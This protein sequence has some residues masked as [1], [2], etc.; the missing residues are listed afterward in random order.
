MNN[1][2]DEN[3]TQKSGSITVYQRLVPDKRPATV[4]VLQ[5]VYETYRNPDGK[6]FRNTRN[7]VLLRIPSG[8]EALNEG[9][10]IALMECGLDNKQIAHVKRRLLELAGPARALELEMD[11]RDA[12]GKLK[13][14]VALSES[15]PSSAKDLRAMLTFAL[16][17][18][19][20]RMNAD[21]GPADLGGRVP[22][23]ALQDTLALINHACGEAQLLYKSLPKGELQDALVLE[24]QRSWFSYPDMLSTFRNR[25]CFSRPAGW[26]GLR[27]QVLEGRIYKSG[28][29]MP[30]P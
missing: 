21:D 15:A 12:K 4:L 24:F 28:D 22:T 11:I 27:T 7:D 29:P 18:V 30:N 25:K 10:V 20:E 6:A 9:E 8:R 23:E 17:E 2:T 1:T 3:L 19:E 26:T 13:S 16:H 5:A 14:V